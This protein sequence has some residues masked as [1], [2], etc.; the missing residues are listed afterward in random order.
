VTVASFESSTIQGILE[1]DR[2]CG[3]VYFL[4]GN[5]KARD[6]GGR[7]WS[8]FLVVFQKGELESDR[9][10]GLVYFLGG[11]CRRSKLGQCAWSDFLLVLHI[12]LTKWAL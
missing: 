2:F 3:L 8:D 9:F 10:C 11:N 5:C 6:L 4:G 7:A 12:C 1:L